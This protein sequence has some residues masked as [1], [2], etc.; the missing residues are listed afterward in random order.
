MRR[1]GRVQR[2]WYRR[3][4]IPEPLS[5]GSSGPRHAHLVRLLP[6]RWRRL[7]MA[8]AWFFGF[9]WIKC[10]LCD[11]PFGGHESGGAI[12]DPIEGP[13]IGVSICS[14]CTRAGLGQTGW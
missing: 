10:P 6:Y 7:H 8:Y 9:F 11:K 1:P 5:T 13:G 4:G 3:L 14:R 12:P 2:L